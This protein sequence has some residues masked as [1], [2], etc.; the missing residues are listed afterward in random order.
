M[1]LKQTQNL[2]LQQRLL[3]QQI[4]LMKLLSLPVQQLE[5]RIREELN[6]NPALTEEPDQEELQ[7][8]KDEWD[9]R[10]EDDPGAESAGEDAS[11]SE[12][13]EMNNN[14]TLEDFMDDEEL[15]SYKYE[16]IN[17][18]EDDEHYE[19]VVIES[20]RSQDGLIEQLYTLP[21]EENEFQIGEY[22][23]GC[24]DDDGYLRRDIESITDDLLFK[25]NLQTT[26]EK[27]SK[28]LK[29]IQTFDPPGVGATSLQECLLLQLNKMDKELPGVKVATDIVRHFMEELSKKQFDKILARLKITRDELLKAERVIHKLNPRPGLGGTQ[30]S[31]GSNIQPDVMVSM[32]NG[33]PE[34]S[35]HSMN[36]PD[37]F[38]SKEYLKMLEEY[39]SKKS[40]SEKEAGKFIREKIE[41][42]K[43]FIDALE[44]RRLTLLKGVMAI[45]EHQEEYFQT[46]DEARLKPLILKDI[47]DKT[48]LDISTVS[49]LVN[50]KYIQTPYGTF[51][52][53]WFFTESMESKDGEEVSNREIKSFIKELIDLENK[54]KP[55]TDDELCEALNQKGYKIAR[56]TVA[57]YREELNIPV[58]RLRKK[59]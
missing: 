15:D 59:I 2:K 29:I 55:L 56:R 54:S 40:K 17:R 5:D 16:T 32:V 30:T 10:M 47:A 57:K 35:L 19:P 45:V 22:L 36:Q 48:G 50:S 43:W 28:V 8:E 51:P 34:I 49:R 58:A 46:G 26:P 20:G 12:P 23:I 44:Q 53:K 24:L 38:I 39:S 27:V 3:P 4:L 14:V 13:V 11:E 42:A 21:L 6:D 52:L 33:K 1:A 37:L 41:Q 7:E 9:G 18:N 31:S 25:L